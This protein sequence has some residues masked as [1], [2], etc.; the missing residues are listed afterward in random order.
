MYQIIVKDK[1]TN[2]LYRL[3]YTTYRKMKE[4]PDYHLSYP[5]LGPVISSKEFFD[6]FEIVGPTTAK[7]DYPTIKQWLY[8]SASCKGQYVIAEDNEGNS[9]VTYAHT[10]LGKQIIQFIK[11]ETD[12][13]LY[14]GQDVTDIIKHLNFRFLTHTQ[15]SKWKQDKEVKPLRTFIS[16]KLG[17]RP[18]VDVEKLF[19]HFFFKSKLTGKTYTLSINYTR[20]DFDHRLSF[21]E[22]YYKKCPAWLKIRISPKLFLSLFEFT[23]EEFYGMRSRPMHYPSLFE[24]DEALSIRHNRLYDPQLD[25]VINL[26]DNRCVIDW[27]FKG[28]F[29]KYGVAFK[30]TVS[31]FNVIT[32]EILSKKK[33]L[34]FYNYYLL[35]GLHEK[36][37]PSITKLNR[38]MDEFYVY[39]V[40]KNGRILKH[41]VVAKHISQVYHKHK[42][43]LDSIIVF[44]VAGRFNYL[45]GKIKEVRKCLL[46]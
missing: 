9:Y 19:H 15:Y 3:S 28:E 12:R 10:T 33:A 34:T 7:V 11:G 45:E 2:Q 44:K 36:D 39:L 26:K 4:N 32:K 29:V 22:V 27:L 8:Q 43:M 24:S 30:H 6:K 35:R 23:G 18:S 31:H 14:Y 46:K 13:I 16:T 21:E 1:D 17:I 25:M 37:L 20:N 42:E 41:A 40:L 38:P 5:G